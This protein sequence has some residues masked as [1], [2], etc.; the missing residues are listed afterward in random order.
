MKIEIEIEIG[1][2][3]TLHPEG[4][5]RMSWS[6]DMRHTGNAFRLDSL[7]LER[8]LKEQAEQEVAQGIK[9]EWQWKKTFFTKSRLACSKFLQAASQCPS[10]LNIIDRQLSY[11]ALKC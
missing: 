9:A 11:P 1:D 5:Q 10:L 4:R 8:G 2:T 3:N 6:S 7:T